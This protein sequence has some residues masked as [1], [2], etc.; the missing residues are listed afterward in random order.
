MKIIMWISFGLYNWICSD[1]DNNYDNWQKV[2]KYTF[3]T[4]YPHCVEVFEEMVGNWRM[5]VIWLKSAF[6]ASPDRLYKTRILFENNIHTKRNTHFHT[7]HLF[8]L[9]CQCKNSVETYRTRCY[10]DCTKVTLGYG[11]YCDTSMSPKTA[12]YF[13]SGGVIATLLG[14]CKVL[15]FANMNVTLFRISVNVTSPVGTPGV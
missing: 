8:C 14:N 13:P 2:S 7:I 12:D 5:R 11:G 6:F 1:T 10:I 9:P 4:R 15:C 3:F